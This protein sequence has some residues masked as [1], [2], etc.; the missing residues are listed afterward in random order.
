MK[1]STKIQSRSVG[2]AALAPKAPDYFI[3]AITFVSLRKTGLV[4]SA[5]LLL[6]LRSFS[7]HLCPHSYLMKPPLNP[8]YT[9]TLLIVVNTTSKH[10]HTLNYADNN[11]KLLQNNQTV[12][13]KRAK[14][15]KLCPVPNSQDAVQGERERARKEGEREAGLLNQIRYWLGR[16]TPHQGFRLTLR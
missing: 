15:Q 8:A 10:K 1:Y 7:V 9:E 13:L 12:K 14:I 3:C 11:C 5:W 4:F 2:P 6:L 16:H